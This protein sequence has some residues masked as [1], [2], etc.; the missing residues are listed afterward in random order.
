MGVELTPLIA[1]CLQVPI[2]RREIGGTALN[3]DMY[4]KKAGDADEVEDLFELL[5]EVKAQYPEVQA[6][7]S[8]AIFSNYQRLRVENCCQRL[9]LISLAYLWLRDQAALLDEMIAA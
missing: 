6:V 9:G 5:A 8:G 4:Y 3:Q 7:A 1:E 2:L